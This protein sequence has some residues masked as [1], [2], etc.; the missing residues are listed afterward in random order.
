MEHLVISQQVKFIGVSH[1]ATLSMCNVMV[2][3]DLDKSVYFNLV[4]LFA[5]FIG[6]FAVISIMV[7]KIVNT[8]AT[9]NTTNTESP[10]T[11]NQ[12]VNV[13]ASI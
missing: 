4:I 8:Y 13:S 12:I 7:S 3:L 5:F 9:I 6:T 10:T 2:Y 1:I 11:D